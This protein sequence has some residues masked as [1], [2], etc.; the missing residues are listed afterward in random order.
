MN[1]QISVPNHRTTFCIAEQTKNLKRVPPSDLAYARGRSHTWAGS[2][3][4][5]DPAVTLQPVVMASIPT[6][7]IRTS[8]ESFSTIS[9]IISVRLATGAG[10]EPASP[11]CAGA[12]TVELPC[13][14][15]S[16]AV[17][18]VPSLDVLEFE[19]TRSP[20]F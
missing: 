17:G 7:S 14:C 3:I 8:G 5:N 11:A 4:N 18:R 15:A 19:V 9:S 10:L 12:L 2:G 16:P 13:I 6:P 1:A 20:A